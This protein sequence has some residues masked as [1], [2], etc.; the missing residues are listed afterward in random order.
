[1]RASNKESLS[2]V[3]IQNTSCHDPYL[4]VSYRPAIVSWT[5]DSYYW[6]AK[7]LY[8]PI[9]WKLN[10][11]RHFGKHLEEARTH[12]IPWEDKKLAAVWVG[13]MTGGPHPS[14]LTDMSSLQVCLWNPR[15][16]FVYEHSNSSLVYARLTSVTVFPVKKEDLPNLFISFLSK[17]EILRYKVVIS[18]EGNDV[19]S[20]LK[21]M[22]FSNSVVMMQPPTVTS[23]SLEELLEPWVHYIP[24]NQDGSNAEEMVKWVSENDLKAQRI[25]ERST[26]YMY[27]LVYHADAAKDDLAIK[28]EILRRYSGFWQ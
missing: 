24:L 7:P 2:R 5:S 18:L 16:R 23:W 21:W 9:I 3:L 10:V 15:C 8:Q 11:E 14:L 27:D 6:D 22:L 1:M 17:T 20:G 26:L 12:D 25:A 19:S 13:H 28:K 4:E